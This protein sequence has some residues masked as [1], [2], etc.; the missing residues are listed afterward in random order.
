MDTIIK[1]L[2]IVPLEKSK[3]V[4]PFSILYTQDGKN[5]RWDCVEA[6]DSVSCIMYHKGFDAFLLVKQFRPSLW[7]YQTRN[8]INSDELGVTY[9]LCAGIMDKG[10][11]P[12]QTILEEILEETGYEVGKVKKITSSYTALGFGANRQTLFCTFIDESMKKTA[13]G[14]VDDERIEIEFIKREEITKFIYDESKVK[15]P[16]LQFAVLWF[17]GHFEELKKIF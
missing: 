13:G 11:S 1:N 16:N 10:L 7:Y 5:K 9:E 6:H 3:F 14:G 4:K 8:S 15:A 12:E 2:E 17:L